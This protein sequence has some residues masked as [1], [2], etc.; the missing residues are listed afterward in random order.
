[1]TRLT[2]SLA[3][4]GTYEYDFGTTTELTLR[5]LAERLGTRQREAVQVLARNNPPVF[6]CVVCGQEATQVC[7]QCIGADDGWLCDA[8]APEHECGEEMSHRRELKC[9]D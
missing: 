4:C 7:T 1:M 8:C 2:R 6:S 3:I 5:V 9:L